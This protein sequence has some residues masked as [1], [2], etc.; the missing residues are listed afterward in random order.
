MLTC[1]AK[2]IRV[3]LMRSEQS[4]QADFASNL[5]EIKFIDAN[6]KKEE[7]NKLANDVHNQLQ[8]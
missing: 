2:C 6:I 3:C 5:K 1:L 4:V 8:R 7:N